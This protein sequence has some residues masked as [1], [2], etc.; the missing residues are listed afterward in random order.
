MSEEKKAIIAMIKMPEMNNEFE[1]FVAAIYS[2]DQFTKQQI[3]AM[4]KAFLAGAKIGSIVMDDVYTGALEFV[5]NIENLT[6]DDEAKIFG[7]YIN[8]GKMMFD[9]LTEIKDERKKDACDSLKH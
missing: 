4:K 3:S 8:A 2:N 1:K 5:S 6:E 7:N 9:K